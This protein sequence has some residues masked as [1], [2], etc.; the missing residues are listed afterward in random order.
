MTL[1][2]ESRQR[3]V[4]RRMRFL[5]FWEVLVLFVGGALLGVPFLLNDVREVWGLRRSIGYAISGKRIPISWVESPRTALGKEES[6]RLVHVDAVILAAAGRRDVALDV[7]RHMRAQWPPAYV[8]LGKLYLEEGETEQAIA[9]WRAAGDAQRLYKLGMSLLAGGTY[10]DAIRAFQAALDAG[11]PHPGEA[12]NS[13][14]L[15][16]MRRGLYEK[17]LNA[18]RASLALQPTYVTYIAAGNAAAAACR[19]DEAIG[20]YTQAIRDSPA[21]YYAYYSLGLLYLQEGNY[22]AAIPLFRH[23][24]A[25]EDATAWP[26]YYLGYALT[27][28]GE[29]GQAAEALG[30]AS[31]MGLNVDAVEPLRRAPCGTWKGH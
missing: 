19:L 25:Q 28:L 27:Q 23:A 7:L 29:D 13:I 17:A 12:Y 1:L 24:A 31:Q 10:A 16:Y 8:T 14:G 21:R 11:Y 3:G 5:V 4:V 9:A 30:R 26:W 15:A 6:P 22:P 18:Y 20:N 2:R